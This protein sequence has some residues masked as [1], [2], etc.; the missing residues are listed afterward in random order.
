MGQSPVRLGLSPEHGRQLRRHQPPSPSLPLSPP[1][2]SP[3][4]PYTTDSHLVTNSGKMMVLD[5]LLPRLREEGHRVLIF[6]QMTRMLDI[7]EDYCLWREYP[8]CRLDGQTA[9]TE[10]QVRPSHIHILSL[11]LL[12]LSH[13]PIILLPPPTH[14]SSS[15]LL[16][17][18]SSSSSPTYHPPSPPIR[19][20]SR[21]TMTHTVTSLSSCCPPVP[22]AWGSTWPQ[23][24]QSSS[25][26]PTGTLRLTCRRR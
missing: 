17:H 22:V 8:Y 18:L 25:M 10:R 1:P 14:L 19:S 21:P 20:T 24:T 6:C 7:L 13:P 3:G 9:H 26:T 11:I 15:S 23:Q 2:L 16:P 4:P 12:P 5:K